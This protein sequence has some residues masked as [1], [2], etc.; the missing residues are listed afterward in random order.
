MILIGCGSGG[1]SS[2]LPAAPS[3][4]QMAKITKSNS[5]TIA[6]SALNSIMFFDTPDIN[7]YLSENESTKSFRVVSTNI[8]R[9]YRSTGECVEGRSDVQGNENRG[10]VT[11]SNCLLSNGAIVNGSAS[12]IKDGAM[13][14]ISFNNF[15]IK[16]GNNYINIKRG[17]F[18][19]IGGDLPKTERLYMDIKAGDKYISF[20]NFNY[21]EEYNGEDNNLIINGYVKTWCTGGYV[22]VETK[23]KIANINSNPTGK[24]DIS[25]NNK[26]VSINFRGNEVDYTDIDGNTTTYDLNDF[27]NLVENSCSA[28]L[29]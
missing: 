24:L 12:Y 16:S 17:D 21:N 14:D 4:S 9:L 3:A 27:E 20:F 11:Y 23:P 25:S 10:S 6:N 8:Q 19:T 2:S 18:I 7:Y 26:R 15:S 5:Q 13:I 29:N 28:S 1:G 22:K